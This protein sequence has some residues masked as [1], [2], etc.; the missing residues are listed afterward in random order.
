[1]NKKPKEALNE[2]IFLIRKKVFI[3]NDLENI[4]VGLGDVIGVFDDDENAY[5]VFQTYEKQDYDL[6]AH[7]E[8]P[9]FF[10]IKMSWDF[11][12][13]AGE[14]PFTVFETEIEELYFLQN[15]KEEAT[16]KAIDICFFYLWQDM[17][18]ETNANFIGLQ[19]TP[20][21]LSKTPDMLEKYLHDCWFI[22]Y[23]EE[24]QRICLSSQLLHSE[25]SDDLE[26]ANNAKESKKEFANLIPLLL[27][28]PFEIEEIN[29][30]TILESG[31]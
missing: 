5:K 31:N 1:M 18:E 19:G 4:F 20:A 17:L 22:D 26:D 16:Q 15:S 3:H 12:G 24:N 9:I 6:S 14:F 11:W 8:M 10:K 7:Q 2:K 29:L 27:L 25:Y 23:D 13:D 30:K 21:Y 28:K